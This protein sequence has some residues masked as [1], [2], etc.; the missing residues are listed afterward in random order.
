VPN[1]EIPLTSPPRHDR[2]QQTPHESP[3]SKQ[4]TGSTTTTSTLTC[5]IE[6]ST[7]DH[8]ALVKGN[9]YHG[10]FTVDPES[11]RFK[12][13]IN[14]GVPHAALAECSLPRTKRRLPQFHV[15]KARAQNERMGSTSLMA[16]YRKRDADLPEGNA[17]TATE[18]SRKHEGHRRPGKSED[19]NTQ[20][21]WKRSV[22]HVA[23]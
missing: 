18:T 19:N 15:L 16:L 22:R 6:E 20:I 1:G 8:E 21:R 4:K 12:D 3:Q 10:P 13:L 14:S 17:T 5:S 7:H 9:P 2:K 11:A 23:D